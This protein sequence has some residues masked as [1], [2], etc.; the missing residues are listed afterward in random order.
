MFW[1]LGRPFPEEDYYDSHCDPRMHIFFSTVA[2]RYGHSELGD[3]ITSMEKGRYGKFPQWHYSKLYEHYFDPFYVVDVDMCD[4]F[5][6]L[7]GTIQQSPDTQIADSVRNNLWKKH[8]GHPQ[9]DLFAVDIQRGR[10][11]RIPSYNH[12]RT[13]Y[14]L[15]PFDTWDDFKSLDKR[16]GEDEEEIKHDLHKVYRNPWECDSIVGGLADDW[17]RTPYSQKHHDY[18]NLGDLF[19]AAV[20]SQFQRTRTGDRFWYSRNL[21]IVNC[22]GDLKPVEHRTLADVIRDNIKHVD[23]PDDVFKVS[24]HNY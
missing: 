9:I 7:A 10:D 19:E 12:V 23:I 24:K 18:S 8:H 6:G 17:V 22:Y 15:K 20:I 21:D 4:L 14:G 1:L 2:F 11:H 13:A 3:Y 5:E 16:L